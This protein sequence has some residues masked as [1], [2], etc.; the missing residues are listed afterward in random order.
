MATAVSCSS[1]SDATSL[2]RPS[3]QDCSS[4]SGTGGYC[5]DGFALLCCFGCCGCWSWADAVHGRRLAD[6]PTDR[7]A[8]WLAAEWPVAAQT[9]D[10]IRCRHATHTCAVSNAPPSHGP[11]R[12]LWPSHG[13]DAAFDATESNPCCAQRP[14]DRNLVWFNIRD[15]RKLTFSAMLY[16]VCCTSTDD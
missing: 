8:G 6:R 12:G 3:E 10:I 7:Q 2:W 5:V 16:V 14:T 1:L 4:S 15:Y 13:Y 9:V 11:L